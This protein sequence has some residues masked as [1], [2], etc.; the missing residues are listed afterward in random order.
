MEQQNTMNYAIIAA[1][2]GSRLKQEGFTDLKPMVS[3]GGERLIER[4][5]RIFKNNEAESITIIINEES[6]SLK[7]LL[8][9]KKQ[10]NLPIQL[11]VKS[12]PSSLH[13]FYEICQRT[14]FSEL[15]LTTVDTIFDDRKFSQYISDFNNQKTIDA[16]MGVTSFVDDEKPLWIEKD[17]T[18]MITRYSSQKTQITSVVSGGIYCFRQKA[19]DLVFKAV[20]RGMSRMRNYQQLLVEQGL[21]V[22]AFDFG[23]IIDID[24]VGDIEKAHNMLADRDN[25]SL[26]AVRRAKTY[27]PNSQA[28]DDGIFNAVCLDL[29]NKGFHV[30]EVQENELLSTQVA[31]PQ[32]VFSMARNP[33]VVDIFALWEQEG[34]KVA[35][36][37][38][39]CKNCYRAQAIDTLKANNIPIPK[40]TI[41]ST[42][43]SPEQLITILQDNN[44]NWIKRADFQTQVEEDV[45]RPKDIQQAQ[46]I[47]ASYKQR[48]IKQ[49]IISEHIDG[50]VIKCY[51][52]RGSEFFHYFY[53]TEDK[54]HFKVNENKKNTAFD[55]NKLQALAQQCAGCLDLDF[56]GID[57]VV[58]NENQFKVIDVN[59]FPSYSSCLEQARGAITDLIVKENECK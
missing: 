23:K 21:Q 43:I 14:P 11:I 6:Q 37:S 52:I 28:K 50:D 17:S 2:E 30:K 38:K 3:L 39:G 13:S 16:L 47:I 53:P 10:D 48:G 57:V 55:K 49:A 34:T 9:S 35:N 7:Q 45:C 41:I 56:F 32:Y 42:D 58:E 1:G 40:T 24:H 36:S 15:C 5:I 44:S 26:L 4:L 12:T 25:K 33:K 51:A 46:K 22:M 31:R 29:K 20:E 59:D 27:S 18:N 19:I 54:F 8:E